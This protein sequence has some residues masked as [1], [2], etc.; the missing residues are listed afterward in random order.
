MFVSCNH[1]SNC[2]FSKFASGIVENED[3]SKFTK[4]QQDAAG[5]ILE[6]REF[7]REAEDG[8][9]EME[10]D[11]N[12]AAGSGAETQGQKRNAPGSPETAQASKRRRQSTLGL[13]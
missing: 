7:H 8:D 3:G 12:A 6:V 1:V 2:S 13:D 4:Q 9:A 5:I 11:V 10:E